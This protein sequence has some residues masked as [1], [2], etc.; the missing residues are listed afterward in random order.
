MITPAS[1]VAMC[2]VSSLLLGITGMIFGHL[3]GSKLA[4]ARVEAWIEIRETDIKSLRRDRDLQR[5]DILVHDIEIGSAFDALNLPRVRRQ[6][7]RE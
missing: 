4:I 2:A 7:I 1:I 5:D 6:A 3:M